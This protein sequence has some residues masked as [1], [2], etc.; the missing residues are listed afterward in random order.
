MFLLAS[1]KTQFRLSDK[2]KLSAL[3]TFYFFTDFK[4]YLSSF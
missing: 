4:T 2:K 1:I 3:S